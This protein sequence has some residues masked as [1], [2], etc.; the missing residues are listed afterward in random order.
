MTNLRKLQQKR[1]V[2][3]LNVF[4]KFNRLVRFDTFMSIECAWHHHVKGECYTLTIQ[5]ALEKFPQYFC[6]Y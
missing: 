3:A 4:I 6:W 2:N 1:G 5:Q